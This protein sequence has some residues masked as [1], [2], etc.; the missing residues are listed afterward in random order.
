M[1]RRDPNELLRG[2]HDAPRR[3]GPPLTVVLDYLATTSGEQLEVLTQTNP[4]LAE[5]ALVGMIYSRTIIDEGS[6]APGC[7]YVENRIEQLERLAISMGG[8]GR[9]DL[10]SALAAGKSDA[11]SSDQT[12]FVEMD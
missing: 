2:N 8:K 4:V 10:I 3:R 6:D 7:L 5:A 9:D 1:A 12:A 11:N